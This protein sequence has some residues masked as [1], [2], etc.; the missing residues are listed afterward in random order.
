[1][2]CPP[3][4]GQVVKPEPVTNAPLILDSVLDRTTDILRYA[5]H[6]LINRSKVQTPE[7]R[8]LM[9]SVW[10]VPGF[11]FLGI[12]LNARRVGLTVILVPVW[13]LIFSAVALFDSSLHRSAAGSGGLWWPAAMMAMGTMVFRL[14]AGGA[15]DGVRRSA[16]LLLAVFIRNRCPIE[17]GLVGVKA[18]IA[19]LQPL[20]AARNARLQAFIGLVW[21]GLTWWVVTWVLGRDVSQAVRNEATGWAFLAGL[22]F[23]LV[24]IAWT[25]YSTASRVFW[26]TLDIAIAEVEAGTVPPG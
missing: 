23:I 9:D 10:H 6:L 16:V 19:A 1:M 8:A 18:T 13:W 5:E 22:F 26:L 3:L 4:E 15:L 21:G 24:S 7:A 2:R 11:L 12:G 20:A 25:S 17:E 14:P